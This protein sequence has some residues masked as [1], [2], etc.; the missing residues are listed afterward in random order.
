MPIDLNGGPEQFRE[1]ALGAMELVKR[2]YAELPDLPVMPVTTSGAVRALLY[3]PLPEEGTPVA[4]A[5][6]IARDVASSEN[7][8][9]LK[10]QDVTGLLGRTFGQR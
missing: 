1:M 2:Y 5:L 8:I 10:T 6:A 4:E 7:A 3:E 9:A